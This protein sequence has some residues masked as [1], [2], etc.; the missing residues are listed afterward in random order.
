MVAEESAAVLLG[1]Q[2]ECEALAEL[3]GAVRAGQGRGLVLRGEPGVGKTALL[4]YMVGRAAGCHVVRTAGV[5][6]EMELA[7]AGLH[8]VCLS[9][10][11]RLERLLAP[12]RDALATAFG[13][14]AGEAP[15][16]FLVGLAALSLL[17]A[18]AEERPLVCVVDDAQWLD[19]ASAQVLA[20]VA[21]RLQAES[22]AVVFAVR[23]PSEE[24]AGLP[25]MVVE[26]LG[27]EDSRALLASVVRGPLDERV[28]D[29]IVAET[30]G[31]PLALLELPRGVPTAKL[32]DGFGLLDASELSR[33]IEES[34]RRRAEPLEA[35]TRML[36]LLAAAEPV[37]DPTLLWRA[38]AQLGIGADAAE[39]AE[40]A[41]L[42]TVGTRVTFFHPLVRSAVYRA[43]SPEERRSAHRALAEAS[44]A[45]TDPDRRAWH[46][47]HS[48]VGPD[49]AVAEELE[50]SAK[51][52]EARGDV[53]AAAAF[54]AQSTA[55]TVDQ[56]QRAARA[57]AAAQ[58]KYQAG[59]F[60]AALEL[61]AVAQAG[62]LAELG[63]ARADLVRGQVTFAS[64]SP[65]E[66]LPLLLKAARRLE[67]L[68]L[69]LARETYRD[70]FF[71][72]P[73]AGRLVSEGGLLKVAEATRAARPVPKPL[74]APDLLLDG[75]AVLITDGYA[76][77]TPILQRALAAFRRDDLP[78]EEALR[79]LP[80]ACRAAHDVW[81][82]ES[83]HVLSTRLVG[84]ARSAGAL[85]VL[86]IALL[87]RL[88]ILVRAGEFAAS[89][90]AAEEA[91][92]VS[93]ATG[94]GLAPYGSLVLAAW[95][96]REAETS[97]LI[98]ANTK[99]MLRRGEGQWLTASQWASAVLY[100]SLARF[101]EALA[102]A[103]QAAESKNELGLS[104]W[105]LSELI[106][107]G[108][109]IGKAERAGEALERLSEM[110]RVSGR[111]W[112]LGIAARCRALV[113]NQK[114]AE[115]HYLE[116]MERLRRTRLRAELARAHLLY[117]EWLRRE[118]RRVDA[119]VHLRTAHEMFDTMGAEGFAERAARE[120]RATGE[121]ARKRAVETGD[122]LTAQ[123]TQVARLTA[124]GLSNAEIGARLFI[125]PNTVNYHL[126]KIFRK[127]D[128]K[129]RTH[130]TRH[131]LE[132]AR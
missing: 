119:R 50:L 74:R 81:D 31:N 20:F 91:E 90:S 87:L 66:A 97:H 40:T 6:S 36:L 29:R 13:L 88:S 101:E 34:F 99:E 57:L 14:S 121:T 124:E 120:L 98:E 112:G 92:A 73:M 21:R 8:Q 115:R 84:L 109:R 11:D 76:A 108:T 68:D 79:W 46:R 30:H 100:N 78:G 126:R 128:V 77:G 2:G 122:Q 28:R 83:L 129:S 72:A 86:P 18:V 23:E 131:V 17:S 42:F 35:E 9:F 62:P 130:L 59:E 48:M 49:D 65:S 123:E 5:Q 63:H 94:S 27:E 3:V 102:A 16:R 44:D 43:A 105:A 32:A 55:L 51:R 80:L 12:Q 89:A 85:T 26:G 107:A 118:R 61:V 106:E 93:E 132:G 22:V 104:A 45:E 47:A 54:L 117:G 1:R 15:G 10:L 111:D 52:A 82:D 60:D 75:M 56:A 38:A 64:R 95:R 24:F 4:E 58:A 7:F 33:R 103:A 116:S 69:G 19:R 41:D 71:A 70:A 96:G 127:L 125:S 25:E 114:G 37:G 53:P 110:T 67:P 113:S 39:P